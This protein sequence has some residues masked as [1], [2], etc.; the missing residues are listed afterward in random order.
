MSRALDADLAGRVS[1][2]RAIAAAYDWNVVGPQILGVFERAVEARRR[3][4]GA[5]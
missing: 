1:A 3:P 4:A 2:G 5:C